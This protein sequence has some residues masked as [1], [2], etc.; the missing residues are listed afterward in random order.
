MTVN[1]YMPIINR[2]KKKKIKGGIIIILGRQN[3]DL[4]NNIESGANWTGETSLR[5]A[6]A[7]LDNDPPTAEESAVWTAASNMCDGL[8]NCCEEKALIEY[9]EYLDAALAEL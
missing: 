3:D 7:I 6:Y 9:C 2:P 5:S 1:K 8:E 4:D